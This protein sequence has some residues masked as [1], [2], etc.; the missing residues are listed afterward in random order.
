MSSILTVRELTDSLRR[1][2]EGHFP[3]VWVKGEVS[4]LSRPGSG[5]L[6][7]SLKDS[8]A[9]LHCV[10]FKGQQRGPERFDPL[11]GEVFEDGPRPSPALGMENGQEFLCAG[12]LSVYAPRGSY[13]LVVE[14]AQPAGQ[15]ALHAAFAALRQ[16]L[17]AQGYFL[18]ERKRPLPRNPLRVAVIT[19][20]T[21][22]VIHDFLRIADTRGH[23]AE[24]RIHPV[25]V[26][27]ETAAPAI[28]AALH[29]ANA[30][31]WAEVIVLIRGGG[32]LEDLWAFNEECVAA[33][34]FQSRLPVL[35]GI[36]HEVDISMADM[37]ADVRAA[38]PT[39]AAQLLW[40]ARD[41]LVQQA[42]AWEGAL[43]EA[44]QRF[45]ERQER[46]WQRQEQALN[47]LSPARSLARQEEKFQAR[48]EKLL[49]CGRDLT[50]RHTGPLAFVVQHLPVAAE[51]WLHRAESR[52]ERLDLG[53][54][55]HSPLAPLERGYALVRDARGA[56][57]RS[58]HDKKI[59]DLVHIHV[60]DGVLDAT[61]THCH[62]KKI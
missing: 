56:V 10:W 2:V 25:P 50:G 24:I 16:K 48:L 15:G 3:F 5:H 12:R 42:D 55:A 44:V 41:E 53:L 1:A 23:G 27:G 61:L 32:S 35:A 18:Q 30:E 37:T 47:W 33:A 26:Q 28:A 20:P 57:L 59:G 4:N 49:R 54:V 22:A 60:H 29:A 9:L 8:E 19:A 51:R 21:G 14:L 34:V 43:R 17:A 39:H 40:P 52:A 58:V 6:Y 31:G 46:A 38:T 11:T 45:W 13:Q 62:E 7:F 36:G